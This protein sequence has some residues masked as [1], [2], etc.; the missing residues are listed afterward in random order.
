MTLPAR[1]ISG[2]FDLDALFGKLDF[3]VRVY[4]D[5]NKIRI[6]VVISIPHKTGAKLRDGGAHKL[7]HDAAEVC[8]HESRFE[9]IKILGMKCAVDQSE[10][11]CETLHCLADM[12]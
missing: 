1:V 8:R 9:S 3:V 4:A 2:S 11:R 12:V 7:T 6:P 5:R 10:E